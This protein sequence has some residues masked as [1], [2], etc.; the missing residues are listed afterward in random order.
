MYKQILINYKVEHQ[1]ILQVEREK[2]QPWFEETLKEL[3]FEK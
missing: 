2:V 3:L 1:V